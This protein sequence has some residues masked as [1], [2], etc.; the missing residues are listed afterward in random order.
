MTAFIAVFTQVSSV[1]HGPLILYF[2]YILS[3]VP[4]DCIKHFLYLPFFFLFLRPSIYYRYVMVL[5]PVNVVFV[6][7]HYT[8][9]SRDQPVKIVQYVQTLFI[10]YALGINFAFYSRCSYYFKIFFFF[11]FHTTTHGIYTL[12][13]CIRK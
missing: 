10:C 4:Y 3:L 13:T 5:G 2:R 6:H 8:V 9:P 12:S 7:V 11:R 1:A